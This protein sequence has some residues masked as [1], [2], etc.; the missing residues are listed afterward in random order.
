MAT[1]KHCGRPDWGLDGCFAEHAKVASDAVPTTSV[2]ATANAV[3]GWYLWGIWDGSV[4]SGKPCQLPYQLWI[5]DGWVV[6]GVG[7]LIE[8]G[9]MWRILPY[10]DSHGWIHWEVED[11]GSRNIGMPV[12]TTSMPT[13]RKI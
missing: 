8:E 4:Y 7:S 3:Q 11:P 13:I 6:L 9:D 12:E 1:C 5:P 2:S 10:S